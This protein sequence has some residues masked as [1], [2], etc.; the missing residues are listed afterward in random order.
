MEWFLATA[1]RPIGALIYFGLAL[2]ISRMIAPLI[3]DGRVKSA[4]YDR[5]IKKTHPWKFCLLGFITFYGCIAIVAYFV[6]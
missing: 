5:S 2:L 1:L 6:L 3:P 4:L